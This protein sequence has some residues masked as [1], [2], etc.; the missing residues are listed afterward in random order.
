MVSLIPLGENRQHIAGAQIHWRVASRLRFVAG[1]INA[2]LL[3]HEF[4]LRTSL[5][6]PGAKMSPILR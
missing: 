5:E 1:R 4:N 6:G 3:S 2:V